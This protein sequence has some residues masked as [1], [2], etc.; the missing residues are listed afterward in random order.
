MSSH[1][2]RNPSLPVIA[3]LTPTLSIT[4]TLGRGGDSELLHTREKGD[5]DGQHRGNFGMGGMLGRH[6]K[7]E[8][9]RCRYVGHGTL[10]M[11]KREG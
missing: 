1:H 4:P 10:G 2:S 5:L 3:L 8:V 6:K 11:E 7:I 9:V